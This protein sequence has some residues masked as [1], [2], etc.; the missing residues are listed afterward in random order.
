MKQKPLSRHVTFR[1]D[2][3]TFQ[4]FSAEASRF[5]GISEVL[6]EC[7]DAFIEKRLTIQPPV[8]PRKE[9]LYHD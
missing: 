6:R 2:D 7:I 9:S 8:T 3:A 4:K 5:G 1:I